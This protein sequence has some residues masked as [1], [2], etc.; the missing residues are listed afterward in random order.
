MRNQLSYHFPQ[1]VSSL[2][3]NQKGCLNP[4]RPDQSLLSS[5]T[6]GEGA[7]DEEEQKEEDRVVDAA[8]EGGGIKGNEF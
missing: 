2:N 3:Q 5:S 8:K 6:D 1:I 4:C 7:R